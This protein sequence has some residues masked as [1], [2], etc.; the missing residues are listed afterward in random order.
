MHCVAAAR[1]VAACSVVARRPAL[2]RLVPA[3][4]TPAALNAPAVNTNA[5]EPPALLASRSVH[6]GRTNVAE[7][8]QPAPVLLRPHPVTYSAPSTSASAESYSGPAPR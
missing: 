1:S 6:A 7:A 2:D 3:D 4:T 8:S 5:V